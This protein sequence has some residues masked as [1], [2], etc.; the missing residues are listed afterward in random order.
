MKNNSDT[1]QNVKQPI[2][3]NDRFMEVLKHYN[4]S[5]YKISQELKQNS[6]A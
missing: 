1:Q 4:Y 6:S 3:I 5:G 2:P